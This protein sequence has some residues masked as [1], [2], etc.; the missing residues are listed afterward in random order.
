MKNENFITIQGW[1][2]NELGLSGNEL[3]CFALVY[4]FSQDEESEFSG[5]LSYV[6]ES[7]NMTKQN[8][9][10]VLLRL[11]EKGLVNKRDEEVAHGIKLCRYSVNKETATA[12]LKQQRGVAKTATDNIEDNIVEKEEKKDKDKS[13]SK[14]E[15]NLP[16]AAETSIEYEKPKTKK[17]VA[18]EIADFWNE[19]KPTGLKEVRS[20]NQDRI[21]AIQARLNSGYTIDDIKKAILLCNSLPD[22]YLGKERG[23][24]WKANFDWLIGNRQGNFVLI[25]EGALHTTN[26]QQREYNRIMASDNT[27]Y[28]DEYHPVESLYLSWDERSQCYVTCSNIE[29]LCD[30]YTD[31][32][33][34]NG[35]KV[36]KNGYTFVWDS[37]I[38]Q[39]VNKQ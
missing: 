37:N 23:K 21:R 29:M 22:F 6:A 3:I 17:Q 28:K 35:A 15:E 11:V 16:F 1:M 4:G 14:K 39:W 7:L 27:N 8:A 19:N 12:W 31:E 24:P 10:K 18:Q 2:V 32:N 30:G 5:S 34:P 20:I 26:E 33:R 38:K 36:M 13:L 9:R 25:L